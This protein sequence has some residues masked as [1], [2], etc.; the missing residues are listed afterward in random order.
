MESGLKGSDYQVNISSS[1]FPGN[2]PENYKESG[3]IRILPTSKQANKY[4]LK[5]TIEKKKLLNIFKVEN[6]GVFILKI[7]YLFFQYLIADSEKN[8]WALADWIHE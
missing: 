7:F 6:T 4:M 3:F 8:Y 5:A 1:K 2:L